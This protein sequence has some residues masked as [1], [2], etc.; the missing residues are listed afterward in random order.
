M[1]IASS[2]LALV[3]VIVHQNIARSALF[4]H[5]G[6]GNIWSSSLP[7]ASGSRDLERGF[8]FRPR[9]HLLS[10]TAPLIRRFFLVSKF[11]TDGR[12][13]LGSP[14]VVQFRPFQSYLRWLRGFRQK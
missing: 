10:T 14:R 9:A 6:G 12:T 5:R 7:P 13:V 4:L 8:F 3:L 2:F 1:F 11:R